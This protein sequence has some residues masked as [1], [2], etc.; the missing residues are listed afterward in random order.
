MSGLFAKLKGLIAEAPPSASAGLDPAAVALSALMV[1]LARADGQFDDGERAEI[2]AALD[3]RFG[4]GAALLEAGEA[5]EAEA[6][7]NHG[8]TRL[9]KAAH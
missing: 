1:R 6:L 3:A 2:E 9:L 4:N 7:D 8:F 5:A